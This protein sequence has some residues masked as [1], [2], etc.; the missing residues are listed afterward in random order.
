MSSPESRPALKVGDHVER[1]CECDRYRPVYYGAAS[2]DFNPIHIDAE[3]G[4]LAGLGG[5]ILQGLCTMSWAAETAVALFG[6]PT[7]L[8]A[9]DVR[10]SKPVKPGD[11]ITLRAEVVSIEAGLA[12]ATVT[13]L[14]QDGVEVLKNGTATGRLA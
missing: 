13:A 1:R 9:L 6:H 14:N 3:V 2:G 10:F 7:R 12:R 11:T 4:Q 8:A 5:P